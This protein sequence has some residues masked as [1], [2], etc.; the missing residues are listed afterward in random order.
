VPDVGGNHLPSAPRNALALT[1]TLHGRWPGDR[2]WY[3]RAGFDV[4]D[5][6]FNDADNLNWVGARH[7]LSAGA[8]ITVRGFELSLW[9]R[10]LLDQHYVTRAGYG[11]TFSLIGP[12]YSILGADPANG[13]RFGASVTYQFA[14]HDR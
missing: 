2:Q 11:P 9:G 6:Q 5:R 7:L 1:A 4:T 13:R 12:P 14:D 3:A 10:N 8:G